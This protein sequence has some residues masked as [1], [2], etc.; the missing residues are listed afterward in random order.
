MLDRLRRG[1]GSWI[2]K[3][4]LG[5]LVLSFAAWG[6]GDLVRNIFRPDT[7][8]AKVGDVG[9]S[10]DQFTRAF[11][12]ELNQLQQRFGGNIDAAQA[13][14]LGLAQQ[15]VN[16]LV[17]QALYDQAA[18]DLGLTVGIETIRKEIASNRAFFDQLGRFDTA[19]FQLALRQS[20]FTEESYVA[21]RRH[22]LTRQQLFEAVTAG[23]RPPRKLAEAIYRY[24]QQRRVVD[25]IRLPY[26]E[27]PVPAEADEATLEKYHQQHATRY[28]AP[29]LRSLSYIAMRPIDLAAGIVV[30]PADVR[31]SYESRLAEFTVPEVRQVEQIL[32]QDQGLAQKIADRLSEGGDFYAVAEQMAQLKEKD[33]KLGEIRRGDLPAEVEDTVFDLAQDVPSKPVKSPFGW[34]IFRVTKIAPGRQRSFEEV[35]QQIA[36]QLK[37]ERATDALYDLSNKVDDA[38][39]GGASLDEIA[40]RFDLK[41][42]RVPAVSASGT[43]V[44]GKP[45]DTLPDIDGFLQTAFETQPGDQPILHESKGGIFYLLHVEGTTP[46]AL[47]PLADVHEKV[48]ADWQTDERK[49]AAEDKAKALA[50]RARGGEAPISL[51][52]LSGF[53]SVTSAPLT[54]EEMGAKA[55]LD[56]RTVDAVF[57]LKTGDVTVGANPAGDSAVVAKLEQVKEIDP[58]SEP[59]GVDELAKELRASIAG[60]LFEQ[61]RRALEGHYSVEINQRM[62]DSIFDQPIVR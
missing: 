25:V 7:T 41:L 58:S 46:A 29:E 33:V 40:S 21:Q 56:R 30:D 31:A 26:S 55:G 14:Q 54:R 45:V 4:F 39:A 24:R 48:L 43:D 27:F 16:D 32:V 53:Q 42:E 37:L 62:V 35:K 6:I 60:D 8:V 34:H 50:E 17:M 36:S 18:R 28:T 10:Q 38:L 13:R 52:K 20:G 9:I 23:A 47:R 2:V 57:D 11:N 61:F 59:K 19:R 51:A 15:T 3:V 22:E 44:D 1:T 49:K 12:R 5:L